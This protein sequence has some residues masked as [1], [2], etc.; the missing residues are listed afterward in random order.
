MC[1]NEQLVLGAAF[2]RVGVFRLSV[3]CHQD[4]LNLRLS[5]VYEGGS[6]PEMQL[7][8]TFRPQVIL[9]RR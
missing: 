2:S 8:I 9:P 6:V 1:K 7:K 5:S 4:V 3:H